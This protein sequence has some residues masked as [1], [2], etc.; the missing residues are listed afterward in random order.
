M[1]LSTPKKNGSAVEFS[2]NDPL[3]QRGS[4]LTFQEGGTNAGESSRALGY[5]YFRP[6]ELHQ[7]ATAAGVRFRLAASPE[8][9]ATGEDLKLPNG[10][11]WS[12][13]LFTLITSLRGRPL[14]N[15]LVEEGLVSEEVVRSL[16]DLA[17]SEGFGTLTYGFCR[18]STILYNLSDPFTLDLSTTYHAFIALTDSAFDQAKW[19][20]LFLDRS[21]NASKNG[22]AV[23][24]GI[25]PPQPSSLNLDLTRSRDCPPSFRTVNTSAARRHANRSCS[26]FGCG[27]SC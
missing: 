22:R 4:Q 27:T 7:P 9:F 13:P 12:R 17:S 25:L 15:K 6:A 2:Q 26:Y 21:R 1:Y 8:A 3:Q 16:T 23:Y 18:G 19:P 10:E 24:K 14:Y 20:D 11:P 5:F